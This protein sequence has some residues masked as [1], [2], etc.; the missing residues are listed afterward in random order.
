[1]RIAHIS[2]VHIRKLKYH[3]EYRAAF[4]D[5]YEK[6][7]E[8]KPDIIVNTGDTFHTKLD[9][10]PESI[11]MMSELFVN[12]ADI[13]PH[14]LILGNHDMNCKNGTRLD[15][16]T[17]IVEN[18]NHS[19]LHLHKLTDTIEVSPGMDLHVLS[20][21]DP[22]NWSETVPADRVNIALYHG[23]VVGAKTDTGWTMTHGDIDI[24]TIEKYDYA[25]LGDIHKTHQ[26][27]DADGRCAYPGS[28]IQQNFGETNDKG[29]LLWDIQ[30]KENFTC[31]HIKVSN[32][33]PFITLQLTP[34]GR[35]PNKAQVPSGA[36]IR[37]VSKNNLPLNTMRKAIEIAKQRFDPESVIFLNRAAG[38]RGNVEDLTDDL[39]TE[40]LRDIKIQE[41]LIDEY[42]TDFQCTPETL[43]RVFELNRKYNTIIEKQEEISRNVNW[44]IKS[45]KFD[46]LFNYGEDNSVD[47]ERLSGIVG[48]FGKNF[49][50][51]S[52]I[53]DAALYTLFNTTSKNERKNLN[54]INQ[55]QTSCH[56]TLELEIGEKTYTIERASKKWTKRLKGVETQEAKTELNFEVFDPIT[57]ETTNLNG[58]TRNETDARIRK[59]FGTIDDFS[60]SSLASQHGALEFIDEGSTRRKEIIAKFLDLEIFDQKFKMAKDDSVETKALLKKYEG[61]E[62]NEEIEQLNANLEASRE[63]TEENKNKCIIHRKALE[64]LNKT[65]HGIQAQI[66]STPRRLVDIT[67]CLTAVESKEELCKSLTTKIDAQTIEIIDRRELVATAKETIAGNKTEYTAAL[68][69]KEEVE[70]LTGTIKL[71]QEESEKIDK[72]IKLLD[73]IPCG[74]EHPTCRFIKDAVVDKA[75]KP[76]VEK[77]LFQS[78]SRKA[79]LNPEKIETV[80]ELSEAAHRTISDLKTKITMT[81][82]SRDRNRNTLASTRIELTELQKQVDDYNQ[83]KTAI[84][85][86]ER[87]LRDRAKCENRIE[88]RN[89]LIEECDNETLQLVK[90]MGSFEEKIS[91]LEAQQVEQKELQDNYAAYD[92]LMRCM[93]S[94]GIAYDVIK[95]KIPVI[96]QEI[97]KILTNIVDFEI[98]FETNKNK[99]DIFIKHPKHDERPIE[100]ASGAEKT[101]GA[102]AVRLALLS[103]SSLP[104]S[105]TFILDEPGTALDEENMDGFIR[106]LELIKV[107]FKTVLLISHLDS[108]KDC[109][110]MQIVIDKKDGYARVNQ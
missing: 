27:L 11:R 72:K 32:P 68:T 86:L 85:N 107:Y 81:T 102:M 98:F 33:K 95:K 50:G 110:D 66:D 103:V 77:D 18:L 38:E 65:F 59:H 79:K 39:K 74:T 13:A 71:L 101:M 10:S 15:A 22:E 2:D 45:F 64:E 53:I 109:V 88:T 58:A 61:T 83:N 76:G 19:D 48:I 57:G 75:N 49:T 7:K 37:L 29:F 14:H 54:V 84:E 67:K 82:V 51:K 52:S 97:A 80:I 6:L 23:A 73:G 30:D 100:M 3:K 44:K 104:K 105:D 26:K 92:L 43:E 93:H 87:L 1:M 24:E 17:P 62:Y 9:M 36:R 16:I 4:S 47:F 60:V 70:T 12:L 89:G 34:K 56:G 35:M 31:E 8:A 20:I 25:L 99:L 55:H 106:I 90:Q 40:N 91:S 21:V 28:L 69:N 94:N 108:L 42:L 63:I 78:L 46:N 5:L 41:E 96:N